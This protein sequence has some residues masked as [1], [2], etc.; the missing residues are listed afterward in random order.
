MK[1]TRAIALASVTAIAL[2]ACGSDSDAESSEDT[3][4][5]TAATEEGAEDGAE[6][7][8]AECPSE[9]VI[10]TD[11][12]PELEHGGTYQLIG[13]DGVADKDTVS[14]SGA[15][16]EQYAVGGLE[17]ITIRTVNFDK[18]NASVLADGDA[19]MAYITSSDIIK[20]SAAVPLVGIAKTLDQDPQMVMWDPAVNDVQEPA[21]IAGTGAQVLHFPGTSYIDFMIAEGI[22]T[23]DQS[24]PSYDGSD[25]AWVADGG[26][27]F[28][29]GFATNE[30]YKYENDIAWKDG[31]PADVSFYTVGELGFENYPAVITM[32][33]S[34]A[35]EL[36][37]CLME[38][39]PVMQQAWIDFLSDPKPITDA[40][41]S[42]NETHDGFWALSEGLN[43]AGM[44]LIESE[45]YA[46][47][48]P[49][50]TYCSLDPARMQTLYDILAAIYEEQGTTIADSVDGVFDNKYCANAP[51]R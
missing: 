39:V 8:A 48:S 18:S 20:D 27:F 32:L 28:Q 26:T 3:T 44:A 49:D 14:Y 6:A 16:Q 38:L 9:L 19:D 42:I 51:G 5:D 7:S 23:A 37:S 36:D 30:V 47:N 43:E 22:M 46:V 11:W 12:Y 45:G 13:P 33:K 17:T 10:Q 31:G 35:E 40:M 41:I 1:A 21:D 4:A 2:A 25:A 15:V 50:G 24:N 34:R 29:Q